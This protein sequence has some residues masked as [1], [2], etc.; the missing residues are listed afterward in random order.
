MKT[1]TLALA[2]AVVAGLTSLPPARAADPTVTKTFVADVTGEVVKVESGRITIRVPQT[3]QTGVTHR[4]VGSGPHARTVTVPKFGV[5]YA[6][7]TH[8]LASDVAVKT[9][10]GK[11]VAI[12]DVRSGFPVQLHVTRVTERTPGEK[13]QSRLEVTRV[14]IP[15]PPK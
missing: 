6:E 11:S 14:L 8:A 10:A 7:S 5:K 2:L 3:V 15:V 1:G 12:A 9:V 13:P 4:R